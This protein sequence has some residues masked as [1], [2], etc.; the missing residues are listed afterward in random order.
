[1]ILINFMSLCYTIQIDYNTCKP[2]HNIGSIDYYQMTIQHY[3]T[4][5]ATKEALC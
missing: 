5:G 2:I 1:M 3:I 4:P